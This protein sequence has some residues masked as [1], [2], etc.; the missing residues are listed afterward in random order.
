MA[1]SR[2]RRSLASAQHRSRHRDVFDDWILTQNYR[3]AATGNR[4]RWQKGIPMRLA[5]RTGRCLAVVV[6]ASCAVLLPSLAL[7]APGSPSAAAVAPACETPGLVVWLDT[8]GNGTAGSIHYTLE[9]TNLSRQACTLNGF[10]FVRATSIS[11]EVLGRRAAFESGVPHT[12]TIARGRTATADLQIVDVGVYSPA[13][14]HPVAAAGLRVYPP[15]QTRARDVPF[16]FASCASRG[17][18]FLRAGPVR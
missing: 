1:T 9:F 7:A 13:A 14:C 8:N 12:V 2:R 4:L 15:N 18:V 17:P 5:L 10:P 16:P 11:R 6:T 3:R